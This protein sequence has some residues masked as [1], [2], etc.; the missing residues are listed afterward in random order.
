MSVI[1]PAT[2]NKTT[3]VSEAPGLRP[4]FNYD[5]VLLRVLRQTE[6]VHAKWAKRK[7]IPKNAGT[8]SI[9]FRKVNKLDMTSPADYMLVEGVTPDSLTTGKQHL[10]AFVRQYG[11]YMSFTDKVDFEE[12][13]PIIAENVIYLGEHAKNLMDELVRD[14]LAATPTVMYA[15]KVGADGARDTSVV[16]RDGLTSDHKFNL[17][18]IRRIIRNLRKANVKPAVNGDYICVVSPDT[19]FDI[20]YDPEFREVLDMGNQNRELVDN[21]IARMAGVRFVRTNNAKVYEGGGEAIEGGGEAI[22]VHASIILGQDAYGVVDITGEGNAR[23]YTKGLGSA[24][25]ED[26]L[27]QRQTVGYKI[28]AFG[29]VILEDAAVVKYEHA[30]TGA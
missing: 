14:V 22:D 3:P 11:A 28:N 17:Y 30:V 7:S 12:F 24:G 23:S 1:N 25:T 21:E 29:A 2:L 5:R 20:L 16:T 15:S 26:P 9:N 10:T 27:N 6:F 13:D 19:E 8:D 4:H 18:D